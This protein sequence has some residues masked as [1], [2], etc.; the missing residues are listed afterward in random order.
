MSSFP[1]L[2]SITLN[3]GCRTLKTVNSKNAIV[4]WH[5]CDICKNKAYTIYI[6]QLDKWYCAD[7]IHTACELIEILT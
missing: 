6:L 4:S 2:L 5:K 3:E 7:C 1:R